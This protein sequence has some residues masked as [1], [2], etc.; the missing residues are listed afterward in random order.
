MKFMLGLSLGNVL[1][2]LLAGAVPAQ[3]NIQSALLQKQAIATADKGKV[4][5]KMP[6]YRGT[7]MVSGAAFQD[8]DDTSILP[9]V[10]EIVEDIVIPIP[11]MVKHTLVARAPHKATYMAALVPD[12]AA[13]E[14]IDKGLVGDANDLNLD[15]IEGIGLTITSPTITVIGDVEVRLDDDMEEVAEVCLVDNGSSADANTEDIVKEVIIQSP[16]L[17]VI[18]K[19]S[20][21]ALG[22]AQEAP[23]V[24]LADDSSGKISATGDVASIRQSASEVQSAIPTKNI[25]KQQ[26]PE[27]SDRE[28]QQRSKVWRT[29]L[30]AVKVQI[31]KDDFAVKINTVR[32]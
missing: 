8:L 13:E 21:A 30:P 19:S 4:A 10:K 17:R 24:S 7:D 16:T 28:A 14:I 2:L 23:L 18:D 9:V 22:Q 12:D 32:C 11:E 1:G 25:A 31:T 27:M 15:G 3:L 5:A 6:F 29:T 26:S 20:G